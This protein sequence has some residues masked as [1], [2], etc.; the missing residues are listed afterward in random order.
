MKN[1]FRHLLLVVLCLFGLSACLEEPHYKIYPALYTAQLTIPG[2][3]ESYS[4]NIVNDQT[5]YY[6]IA[7]DYDATKL[8]DGE[9]SVYP[10]KKDEIH[11]RIWVEATYLRKGGKIYIH[12][13]KAQKVLLG[14]SRDI[15]LG[16]FLREYNMSIPVVDVAE[17]NGG[18]TLRLQR[19]GR[20]LILNRI[21]N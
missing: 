4:I 18:T 12:P 10:V 7:I 8:K 9:Q 14:A 20:G 17:H 1:Y 19:L 3:S 2:G 15:D 11:K 5:L 16:Q 13:I 21:F 6:A